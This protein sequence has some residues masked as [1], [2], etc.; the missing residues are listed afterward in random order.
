MGDKESIL[1]EVF[2]LAVKYYRPELDIANEDV[3]DPNYPNSF[4]TQKSVDARNTAIVLIEQDDSEFKDFLKDEETEDMFVIVQPQ[5]GIGFYDANQI[6]D[7]FGN[8][9]LDDVYKNRLAI[10]VLNQ[11]VNYRSS[12]KP[13]LN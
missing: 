10:V 4:V 6:K 2:A 13:R 8:S 3:N 5:G 9:A 1:R 12:H 11:F 7:L